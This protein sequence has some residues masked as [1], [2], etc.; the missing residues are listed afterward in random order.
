MDVERGEDRVRYMERVTW[1]LTLPYVIQPAG[2]CCM[3]QEAQTRARY[4][5]Q[6]WDGEGGQEGGSTGKGYMYTYG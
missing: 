3:T 5:P 6:G 1:K 2:I 4:Q